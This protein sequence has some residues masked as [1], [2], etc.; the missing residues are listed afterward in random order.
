MNN[1]FISNRLKVLPWIAQDFKHDIFA[2]KTKN[3]VN[4]AISCE[5]A[6]NYTKMCNVLLAFKQ[7]N[8]CAIDN[9]ND[10]SLRV[11]PD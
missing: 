9:Q 11:G 2:K 10:Q 1:Y 6:K 5:L 4:R 8:R 7:F 3:N